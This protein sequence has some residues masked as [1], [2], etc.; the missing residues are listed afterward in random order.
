MAEDFS[1]TKP[2]EEYVRIYERTILNRS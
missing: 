1:W 2:A